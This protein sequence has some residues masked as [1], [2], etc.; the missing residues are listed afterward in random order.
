MDDAN[1]Y[2][3][4]IQTGEESLA[5]TDSNVF[6]Q[7]FGTDGQTESIYLPPQDIFAFESGQTD[8]FI[9]EAP[10]LG[11]LTQC[12]IGH[13]STEDSGWYVVDVRIQQNSSGREWLFAFNQWLGYEEA[14]KLAACA[15]I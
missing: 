13:D 14:G 8:K 11:D 7:L 5:G 1:L 15:Q 12:C 10:E 6:I 3:L 2:T 4:W 9:L